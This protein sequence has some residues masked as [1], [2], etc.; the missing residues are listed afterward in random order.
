VAGAESHDY[1]PLH[2]TWLDDHQRRY[3]NGVLS[4][5]RRLLQVRSALA[6]GDR[7]RA[8]E[9]TQRLMTEA[10]D[11]PLSEQARELL[12]EMK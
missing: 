6:Q 8:E 12:G 5:E 9:E 4:Q 2:A 10:S 3:P 11:S 7:D 1:I